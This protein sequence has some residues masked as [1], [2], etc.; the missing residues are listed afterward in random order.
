MSA[1][2]TVAPGG[3]VLTDRLTVAGA[4]GAPTGGGGG[5]DH[6]RR[7]GN[8]ARPSGAGAGWARAARATA[9]TVARARTPAIATGQRRRARR[10]ER[11][12]AAVERHALEPAQH[13]GH[14]R[15]A[16]VGALGEAGQHQPGERRR[17]RSRRAG[18]RTGSGG[19]ALVMISAESWPKVRADE[20][21]PPGEQLVEDG[22]Q[23]VDVGAVVDLQARR[24]ARAP[25][26]AACPPPGPRGCPARRRA[27]ASCM[28]LATP[29]SSTLTKFGC[30]SRVV[31]KRLS[32][33]RSRCTTPTACAAPSASAICRA[34]A[35]ASLQR[36]RAGR[37]GAR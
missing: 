34:M 3:V 8:G 29:K 13:V 30:P 23:R 14:R 17:G 11:G 25:C 35:T 19:G 20:G 24:P 7:R 37:R 36:H 9:P 33:L 12:G 5:D 26:S 27:P 22:A 15:R 4:L 31:R 18:W 10:G 2:R 32:G 6:R 16:L 21:R 1:R 28:S